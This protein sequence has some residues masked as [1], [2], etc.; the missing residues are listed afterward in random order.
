MSGGRAAWVGA[1]LLMVGC[2]AW[3]E[4][5]VP[6]G[7]F[8]WEDDAA[9]VIDIDTEAGTLMSGD[10]TYALTLLPKADWLVGCPTNFGGTRTETWSLSPEVFEVGEVSIS[11][12]TL[13][14]ECGRTPLI[15]PADLVTDVL[16][17][18]SSELVLTFLATE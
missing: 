16:I 7:T 8:S 10:T 9:F 1:G 2:N 3:E 4:A 5:V 15:Y 13:S 11:G 18:E 14:A 17:D 6:V 12:A